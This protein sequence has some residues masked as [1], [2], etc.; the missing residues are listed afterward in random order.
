MGLLLTLFTNGT[1][2][3]EAIAERLAE[4][5]PNR[6]EITLYGATASTY[7]A[8]TGV[9]G[10]YAR[11]CAGIETLLR[12]RVPLGLKT[13]ITR[14]NVGELEAMRQ[15]AHTWGVPFSA[16]WLLSKRRDG[17][18]SDVD[19]CRLSAS[20]CVGLE[21]TDR[22][23][24]CEWT[25]VALQRSPLEANSDSF[26]CDAGKAAFII[27]SAGEM[28]A[29]ADLP[30]PAARPLEIGFE[31]AWK[32]VQR[33]V[34]KAPPRAAGCLGCDTQGYCRCCPAWSFLE[35][36]TLTEPVPYLCAIARARR[37]HYAHIACRAQ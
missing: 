24:A 26:Q 27:N 20:A 17:R 12:Y 31:G 10:S 1:L 22:A 6:T 9:T 2:I 15:M 7:E 21:G 28:N 14:Q 29:C 37:E 32:L 23:S 8:V 4:A 18:H 13:T 5:P 16:G 36:K 25:K 19:D 35:T 34:D 3:R 33:F 11:C 30:L